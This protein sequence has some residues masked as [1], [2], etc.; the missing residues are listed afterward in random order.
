VQ[1][2]LHD[3]G[4]ASGIVDDRAFDHTDA[5]ALP[6]AP[7]SLVYHGSLALRSFHSTQALAGLLEAAA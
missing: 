4:P 2:S 1:L 3:G 7:V 5:A 6:R